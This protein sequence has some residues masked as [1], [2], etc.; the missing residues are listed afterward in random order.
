MSSPRLWASRRRR[1]TTRPS[2]RRSERRRIK[3]A[4]DTL[5]ERWSDA[6]VGIVLLVALHLLRVPIAVIIVG[7][8]VLAVVW[9]AV[10]FLLNRQY[11]RAFKEAL[12][13]GWIEPE[14]A[15]ESMRLPE[16]RQA[17]QAALSSDDERQVLLALRLSQYSR[18]A[19]TGRAVSRCLQHSSPDV[20]AA[21]VEAMEAMRLPDRERVIEGLLAEPHEGLRRAAVGYLLSCGREPI[22]FAR[23]LLDGD[24]PA[25]RRYLLDVLIDHPYEAR[26][27][28]TF[29]WIDAR[30]ASGALE[31]RLAAA[32]ALGAM[33]GPMTA[34]R[35]RTLL[36]NQDVDVRRA[37]LLSAGGALAACDAGRCR[38]V[39][40]GSPQA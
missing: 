20:R 5:V 21:A 11:G 23:R 24:D 39:G 10:L 12:S 30:L 17:L 6:L 32:H 7:T 2:A 26:R 19:E 13:R 3:P 38:L 14:V 31:D 40:T 37:A 34:P 25:L 22:A 29:D 28:L 8:A 9:L 35:L 18:D 1:S 16:A 4:L 36:A 33:E 27:V 15:P